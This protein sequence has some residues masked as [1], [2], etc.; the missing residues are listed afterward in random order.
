MSF[1]WVGGY[2][3]PN[4]EAFPILGCHES[5][6]QRHVKFMKLFMQVLS[7]EAELPNKNTTWGKG[8]LF[9]EHLIVNIRTCHCMG[10]NIWL[11]TYRYVIAWRLWWKVLLLFYSPVIWFGYGGITHVLCFGHEYPGRTH[12]YLGLHLVSN[13]VFLVSDQLPLKSPVCSTIYL[14]LEGE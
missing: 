14:E 13:S 7:Y 2:A 11:C 5:C 6:P 3:C 10:C 1:C 8:G 9:I 12:P 4:E